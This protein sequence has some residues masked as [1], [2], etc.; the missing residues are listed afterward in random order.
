MGSDLSC[1]ALSSFAASEAP[2]HH[3]G[4]ELEG[5]GYH[6]KDAA[7]VAASSWESAWIDLGGEG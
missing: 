3:G 2:I 4:L 6:V 7:D 1:F 5:A